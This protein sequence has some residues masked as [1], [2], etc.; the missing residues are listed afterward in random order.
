M[1]TAVDSSILFDVL[2][3]PSRFHEASVAA[4][5]V[6]YDSGPIVICEIVWA[7]VRAHFDS[8]EA[9][10]KALNEVGATY[11]PTSKAAAGLAGEAWRRYR[12]SGGKRN[13]LI[14]DFLVGAHAQLQADGLLTRD[15]GFYR[16]QFKSLRVIDPSAG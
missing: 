13:H 9:C 1:K 5:K 10:G 3:G 7:E 6:A 11:E 8:N 12:K 16:S 2:G 14:P 15:R 4:L